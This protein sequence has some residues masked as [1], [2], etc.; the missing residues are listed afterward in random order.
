MSRGILT[1]RDIEEI[2]FEIMEYVK[3]SRIARNV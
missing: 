1:W 3:T 2:A